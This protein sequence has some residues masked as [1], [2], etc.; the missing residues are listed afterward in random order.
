MKDP[1]VQVDMQ[2]SAGLALALVVGFDVA[3]TGPRALVPP[4]RRRE[5]LSRVRGCRQPAQAR[6]WIR[7]LLGHLETSTSDFGSCP[8]PV[9]TATTCVVSSLWSV[10]HA[11]DI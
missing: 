7:T 11:I 2:V 10:L 4:R 5:Q 3:R 6:G 8:Q 9:Q 1:V